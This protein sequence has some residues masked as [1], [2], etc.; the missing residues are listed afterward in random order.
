MSP[1]I[2]I[3]SRIFL[4][5]ATVVSAL[6]AI[7]GA[8]LA[9]LKF[10]LRK[11]VQSAWDAY[12]GWLAMIP[13]IALAIVLGR[14]AVIAGVTL[15][16]AFG[17]REFARAT[18]LSR[19]R[20]AAGAVYVLVLFTGV[21]AWTNRFDAFRAMP[22]VAA[23]VL[24]ILPI[25][26]NRFEGQLRTVSLSVF[27]FVY[28][29][30]M[31]THIAFLANGPNPYGYLIFLP[32]ATE[33]NDVSAFV[34]GRLLGRRALRDQISPRKTWS[35]ALGALAVSLAL[36]WALRFLLPSFSAGQ[37]LLAGL[38]TG[39]GGQ[40]GDLVISVFKRDMVVKDLGSGIPGHG[41]VLDR[42]DSLIFVAA[43]FL[44][45]VRYVHGM[46]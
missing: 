28:F 13:I 21:I 3:H 4:I 40:L 15:L 20:L 23:S 9:I 6:V 11:N 27:A 35:G 31:F 17:F 19:D 46:G 24:V 30:W 41:G 22:I 1:F 37:L 32:L 18:G 42:I 34:F 45:L 16:S 8:I 2:A 29:C 7:A 44:Y 25:V 12:T 39:I 5:S 36:P 26:R 38:L 43:P 10:G 14:W 33:L